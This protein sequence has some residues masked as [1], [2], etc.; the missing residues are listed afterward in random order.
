[1]NRLSRLRPVKT[2]VDA[3]SWLLDN[4]GA[5]DRIRWVRPREHWFHHRRHF[6]PLDLVWETM[7]GISLD[8]KAG[9]EAANLDDL[10]GRLEAS[11]RLVRID[12]SAR[13][14]MYRIT[15][16]S[17]REIDRLREIDDVIRLG[18]VRRIEADR[19]VLEQG[20]TDTGSDVIHVDCTARGLRSAPVAPVFQPGRI[21][22]Q[23]IR[24]NSPTFNAALIAFVETHRDEDADKNRLCP[25]NPY[26][27][28]IDDWPG[29]NR[30]TWQVEQRWLREPDLSGWVSTSRLNLLR[31][32]PDHAAEPGVKEAI[33]R[34][35]IHVG[36]AAERLRELDGRRSPGPP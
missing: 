23:Q 31:G 6:Q 18:R 29:L 4:D 9:A 36:P 16:L 14:T 7:E 22:L 8:A 12:P 1:M 33:E 21:V 15:M 24:Q 3:C 27:S 17:P 13:A 35:L 32:L 11:G 2:A 34:F 5:P 25:P 19:I 28:S 20:E 26:P 10:F 30:R